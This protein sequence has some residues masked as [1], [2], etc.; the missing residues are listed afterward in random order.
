MVH[1]RS[2]A[3]GEEGFADEFTEWGLRKKRAYYYW[4]CAI[5][6]KINRQDT[7]SR[8][9][10]RDAKETEMIEREILI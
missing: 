2:E 4:S 3:P 5:V 1:G 9:L 8:V 7:S 10:G 6:N